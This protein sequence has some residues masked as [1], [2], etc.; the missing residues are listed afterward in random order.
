MAEERIELRQGTPEDAEFIA[1]NVMRGMGHEDTNQL[2][3]NIL[4]DICAREDTLY[5]YRHTRVASLN[6]V[7]AGSLT[8][9]DGG[10]YAETCERTWGIFASKMGQSLP[11][12]GKETKA[13]E[14]Y[15]D[16]LAVAPEFRGRHIGS[17]LMLD[18]IEVAKSKG[19]TLVSL[20]ADKEKPGLHRLYS[21][22]GFRPDGEILFF[23]EPY[24]RM[25]Q[26]I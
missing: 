16:S 26:D 7:P 1:R 22:L 17:I 14:F 18:G 25:I 23:G 2:M 12:V 5:S 19:F 20:I 8:A 24:I 10:I 13:G 3:L 15:L 4:K 6:G 11:E 9:Y 21:G